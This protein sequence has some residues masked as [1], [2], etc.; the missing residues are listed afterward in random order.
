[1]RAFDSEVSECSNR[2]STFKFH[3]NS[4]LC[5]FMVVVLHEPDDLSSVR[6]EE[7]TERLIHSLWQA[8]VGQYVLV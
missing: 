2:N 7:E 6:E 3:F 1:M 4:F 8:I 5:I